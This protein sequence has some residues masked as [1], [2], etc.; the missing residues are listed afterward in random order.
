MTSV[1]SYPCTLGD[2]CCISARLRATG[3]A[4][5]SP[6]SAADQLQSALVTDSDRKRLQYS[7][8]RPH[9]CRFT[10]CVWPVVGILP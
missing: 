6:L 8:A 4:V 3:D 2:L 5:G 10:V 7:V 1:V 9:E